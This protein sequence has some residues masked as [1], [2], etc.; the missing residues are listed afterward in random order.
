MIKVENRSATV[1]AMAPSDQYQEVKAETRN[2]S[3]A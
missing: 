1:V 3:L 2:L